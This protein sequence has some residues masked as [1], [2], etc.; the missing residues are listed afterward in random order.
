M[1]DDFIRQ[2]VS[3]C[4]NA[5]EY[6]PCPRCQSELIPSDVSECFSCQETREAR[7]AMNDAGID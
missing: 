7:D 5:R 1:F 3:D 6:R 2:C 4:V